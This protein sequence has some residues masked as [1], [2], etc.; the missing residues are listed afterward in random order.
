MAKT[1][2]NAK[3][4]AIAGTRWGCLIMLSSSVVAYGGLYWLIYG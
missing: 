3:P 1:E 2:T 4:M